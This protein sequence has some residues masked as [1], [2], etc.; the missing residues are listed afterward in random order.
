MLAAFAAAAVHANVTPELDCCTGEAFRYLHRQ[1]FEKELQIDE[2]RNRMGH[3]TRDRRETTG[4]RL[5]ETRCGNGVRR[6]AA[7]GFHR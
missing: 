7:C 2:S 1:S 3:R 6:P 5:G 4:P